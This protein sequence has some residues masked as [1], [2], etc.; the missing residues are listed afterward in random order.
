MCKAFFVILV[1][2]TITGLTY[3]LSKKNGGDIRVVWYLSALTAMIVFFVAKIA[4]G[5]GVIVGDEFVGE[6]GKLL[7]HFTGIML[8]FKKDF[9]IV[10]CIASLVLVPQFICYL[11]SG[12]SG[13]AKSPMLMGIVLSFFF[14][15]IIKSLVVCASI[16][17]TLWGLYFFGYIPTSDETSW[18]FLKAGLSFL[19]L[20]FGII[21][22]YREGEQL[23]NWVGEHV[24]KLRAIHKC[25]TR[26][27]KASSSGEAVNAVDVLELSQSLMRLTSDIH[28]IALKYRESA[29]GSK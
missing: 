6:Y 4:I 7:S 16:L 10:T 1:I 28:R 15:G 25:F 19:L 29:K 2:G 20:A 5:T 27:E 26:N 14:W 3:L 9:L 24:P 18:F 23:A 11:L 17:M 13:N 21:S 22:L 12:L 8:D